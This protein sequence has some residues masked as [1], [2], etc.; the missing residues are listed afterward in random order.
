LLLRRKVAVTIPGP[1]GKTKPVVLQDALQLLLVH[2]EQ[3]PMPRQKHGPAMR[4]IAR[5]RRCELFT[6]AFGT[7][8]LAAVEELMTASTLQR[9]VDNA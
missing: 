4:G 8:A 6:G 9:I 2:D 5:E 7:I 1:I 3:V